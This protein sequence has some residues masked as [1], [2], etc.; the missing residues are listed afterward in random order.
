MPNITLSGYKLVQGVDAFIPYGAKPGTFVCTV[1]PELGQFLYESAP[2]TL[3]LNGGQSNL[4]F[5][6]LTLK[7]PP[8]R[9]LN[10]LRL[11]L[12]DER[13]KFRSIDASQ[14]WNPRTMH[15]TTVSRFENTLDFI[16]NKIAAVTG[17]PISM[18]GLEQDIFF[19]PSIEHKKL[20]TFV[21]ELLHYSSCRLMWDAL[22]QTWVV[23]HADNS[24]TL[25]LTNAMRKS[26]SSKIPSNITLRTGPVV[27]QSDLNVR[28][29]VLDSNHDLITFASAGLTAADYFGGFGTQLEENSAFRVWEI[30]GGGQGP[31]DNIRTLPYRY[32]T[33]AVGCPPVAMEPFFHGAIANFDHFPSPSGEIVRSYAKVQTNGGRIVVADRPVLPITSG[34]LAE[35]CKVRIAY[36]LTDGAGLE[37]KTKDYT[38]PGGTEAGD[39]FVDIP[40]IKPVIVNHPNTNIPQSTWEVEADKLGPLHADR[41]S[42]PRQQVELLTISDVTKAPQVSAVRYQM[43]LPPNEMIRMHIVMSPEIPAPFEI[44]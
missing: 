44:I 42:I 1:I 28:T 32:E 20:D 16:W 31:V 12:E 8:A 19:T 24:G 35:T 25:N 5:P 37:R 9:Q 15:G 43:H 10:M 17:M 34:A 7:N 14:C 6:R 36:N 18:Q 38:V 27:Y 23:K 2:H 39:Y 22:A 21:A 26:L 41:M 33:V 4:T 30:T 3:I 29:G 13:A 11:V 40:Q